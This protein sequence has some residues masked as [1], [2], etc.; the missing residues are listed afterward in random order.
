MTTLALFWQFAYWHMIPLSAVRY[1]IRD[2]RAIS[3]VLVGVMVDMGILQ[4][5][6]NHHASRRGC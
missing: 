3:R 5:E 1:L 2:L 6:Q 4:V